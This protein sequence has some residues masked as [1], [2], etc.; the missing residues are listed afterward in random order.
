MTA[1]RLHEPGR[2]GRERN[3]NTSKLVSSTE[4]ILNIIKSGSSKRNGAN[5]VRAQVAERCGV[6]GVVSGSEEDGKEFE[7]EL[8]S[9]LLGRLKNPLDTIWGNIMLKHGGSPK[10]LMLCGASKGEGTSF[11]AFYLSIFLSMEYGL[12]SIYV[13]T[14]LTA[15]PK[16]IFCDLR[17]CQG[18]TAYFTGELQLPQIILKTS[19]ENFHILPSGKDK[20]NFAPSSVISKITVLKD[21][22][23]YCRDNFDIAIFDSQPITVSPW[24][25]SLAKEVDLAVMVCKYASSRREVS[26]TVLDKLH[27]NGVSVGGV[28]MNSRQFPV[29]PQVY[30]LLK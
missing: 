26:R 21:M 30:N 22:V 3:L 13:D 28:I 6:E 9:A 14:S 17:S 27:E 2:K 29:P 25:I 19:L 20:P 23:A 10:T 1:V 12:K 16:A 15:D 18:L 8:D 7:F 11:I 24:G 5:T 4:K